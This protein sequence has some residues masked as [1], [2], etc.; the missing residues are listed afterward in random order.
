MEKKI[1]AS[2]EALDMGGLNKHSLQIAKKKKIQYLQQSHI[3]DVR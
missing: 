2:T 3:T 1:L